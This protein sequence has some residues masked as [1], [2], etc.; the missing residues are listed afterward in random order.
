[1]PT[2]RLF[3]CIITFFFGVM[4]VVR[5]SALPPPMPEIKLPLW[6]WVQYGC[7]KNR[8]PKFRPD[9]DENGYYPQVFIEAEIPDELLLQSNFYLWTWYCLNGWQIG[10]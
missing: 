2:H 6:C 8:K 5:Q 7:Y 3:F 4:S 1:M 9:K 10:D